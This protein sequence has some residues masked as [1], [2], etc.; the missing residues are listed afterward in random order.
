VRIALVSTPFV[1]VPPRGYGGTELIL[2]ELERGLGRAGHDVTLFA[3]GDSEGRD[4]RWA[5]ERPVWPPERRT[6]LVHCH[7]V[8]REIAAGRFDLV[9]SHVPSFVAFAPE[10]DVPVVHTLHHARDEA[11]LATYLQRPQIRY[12]AISARQAALVPELDC[13]V[14][15]HGLDP[16]SVS[17][18]G[19]E[20]GYALF[21][22]RL[23][24]CKAPDL[25]VD[26]ARAAGLELVV[27]GAPHPED[28]APPGWERD[29][30]RR[31]REP[32]VRRVGSVGGE[33]KVRLLRGARVLLMP[34]RWEEPF[35]LVLVESMLAGT[36]V[37][38]FRRGAAPEIVE[39][40]ITGF[41]VDDVSGMA[42]AAR[43]VGALDREACRRRAI[44]RFS[45]MRMVRDHL[46]VYH[47][48]LA[49]RGAWGTAAAEGSGHAT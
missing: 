29:L 46:R 26:A 38:A 42:D 10:L 32:G 28:D 20:G 16:G 8:A 2:H 22:G 45:A 11:L 18:G 23:V 9:H 49:A 19:G 30:E 36:P 13:A 15:Q 47:A 25:A 34:I 44:E 41:L 17:L 4:V 37:V 3:T 5:F 6:E 35:G 24:W 31:L 1:S 43:R 12:V 33:R 39:D 14:V 48:A 21:L 40:G 7:A 27:A